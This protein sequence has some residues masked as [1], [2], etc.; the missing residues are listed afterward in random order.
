VYPSERARRVSFDG[1]TTVI[2]GGGSGIGCAIALKFAA[3]GATVRI[4]D[5]NLNDAEAVATEIQSAGGSASA[6][7]CDVTDQRQ[8]IST[9]DNL[10]QQS[11]IHMSRRLLLSCGCECR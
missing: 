10:T 2:T 3:N 6:H 7:A 11:R 4:L 5:V 1:K 9:F 8:V